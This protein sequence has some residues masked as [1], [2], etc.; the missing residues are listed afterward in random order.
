MDNL[1]T[2]LS[3][4]KAQL[5]ALEKLIV[6]QNKVINSL[7]KNLSTAIRL[8]SLKAR[9]QIQAQQ[10]LLSLV[11]DVPGKLGCLGDTCCQKIMDGLSRPILL[12]TK[13]V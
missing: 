1:D 7:E 11:G 4:C 8:E 13:C 9:E 12:K 6:G 3:A 5:A 10:S 2:Q